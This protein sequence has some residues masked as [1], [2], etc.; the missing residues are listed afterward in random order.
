MK[1]VYLR[2]LIETLSVS[3]ESI[4][5]VSISAH[6]RWVCMHVL[7]RSGVNY[8]F[9]LLQFKYIFD[10]YNRYICGTIAKFSIRRE[11]FYKTHLH[12]N[13]PPSNYKTNR[14]TKAS[15]AHGEQKVVWPESSKPSQSTSISLGGS[16]GL[17]RLFTRLHEP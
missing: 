11:T 4:L 6:H 12:I 16:Y 15:M 17:W 7:T 3:L 14:L 2:K 5:C 13:D 10:K 9:L 1:Q 8:L